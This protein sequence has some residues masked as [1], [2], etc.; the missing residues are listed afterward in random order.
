MAKQKSDIAVELQNVC[1][2]YHSGE[3]YLDVLR[4]IDLRAKKGQI[5]M[6]TGPSGCGKTTLLSIIAGT[7]RFDSGNI[8]V[9]D[10][11]FSNLNDQQ[12]T[13]FRRRHIGFIFQQFHLLMALNV[14][15]NI[16]IPLL[17][18][19]RK[20]NEALKKASEMLKKVGLRGKENMNPKRLSGG[21]QQRVA[22]ARALIHDPFLVICDEPTASLDA[23]NGARIMQLITEVVKTPDRCAIIVTH[24]NRIF[25]YA[26]TIVQ[27][28]DGV[29]IS[30]GSSF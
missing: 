18:N 15:E 12:M 5:L 23:D 2:R 29:I 19:G 1:K 9:F 16:A 27:M 28:E 3:I 10:I 13:E 14:A 25:K 30:N 17:L 22:I 4:G 7:L 8:N 11:D 21:E 24:D 6:I 26:D 20:R